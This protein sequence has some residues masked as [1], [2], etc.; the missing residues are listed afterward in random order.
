[1]T[2]VSKTRSL[3]IV[4]VA[5]VLAVAVGTAWLVWGPTRAGCGWT[6]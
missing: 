3:T 6:R 5:Y 4:V 1:M 2:P